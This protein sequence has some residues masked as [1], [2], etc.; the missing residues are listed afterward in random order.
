MVM[1]TTNDDYDN[2]FNDKGNLQGVRNIHRLGSS[3]FGIQWTQEYRHL[4]F[5]CNL[6]CFLRICGA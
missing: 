4:S 3:P 5:N 1:K 2:E 6:R